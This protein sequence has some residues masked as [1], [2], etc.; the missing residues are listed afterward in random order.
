MYYE[1]FCTSSRIPTRPPFV[2]F[3]RSCDTRR[4]WVYTSRKGAGCASAA[5]AAWTALA[6][7]AEAVATAAGAVTAA[8]WA[9]G[10]KENGKLIVRRTH[11]QPQQPGKPAKLYQ[12]P[13]DQIS[14]RCPTNSHAS[15]AFGRN[16]QAYVQVIC[17]QCLQM[18]IF[19]GYGSAQARALLVAKSGMPYVV[20]FHSPSPSEL[21]HVV[22]RP[23]GVLRV[24]LYR[25][26][27]LWLP[28]TARRR[29]GLAAGWAKGG[30]GGGGG[31][32]VRCGGVGT[33]SGFGR[34]A[35]C[36]VRVQQYD[37]ILMLRE[38]Y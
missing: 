15:A 23:R 5:A 2:G 38:V 16:E 4:R 14:T 18:T 19:G 12:A 34:M 31:E 17:I 7:P 27:P 20:V 3:G 10:S 28:V 30:S 25:E 33:L 6:C 22:A 36:G 35:A 8:A 26:G 24:Q 32:V 13:G 37:I 1:H 9:G 11:Y 21:P 29:V